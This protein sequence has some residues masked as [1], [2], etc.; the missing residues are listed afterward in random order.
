M[1]GCFFDMYLCN[2][3]TLFG[4]YISMFIPWQWCSKSNNKKNFWDTQTLEDD[5]TT[6]FRNART[7]YSVALRRIHE[8]RD[9]QPL[10]RVNLARIVITV[11]RV[12]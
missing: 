11:A 6:S 3:G 9:P 5:C 2:F 1:V 10:R 8:K 4:E 7:D 12:V